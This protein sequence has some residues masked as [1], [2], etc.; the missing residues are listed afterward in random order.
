MS[1][2]SIKGA[3]H[4][5]PENRVLNVGGHL[6]RVSYKNNSMTLTVMQAV[7]NNGQ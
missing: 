1:G 3:L 7:P 4:A 6:F 2:K 5:L